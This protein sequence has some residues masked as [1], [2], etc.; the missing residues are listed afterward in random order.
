MLRLGSSL[1]SIEFGGRGSPYLQAR[2][3]FPALT[4]SRADSYK[5]IHAY[6]ENSLLIL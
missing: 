6:S 3:E 4:A 1:K 5:R 2:M